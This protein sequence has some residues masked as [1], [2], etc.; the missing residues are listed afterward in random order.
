MGRER[1]LAGGRGHRA[2]PTVSVR[3]ARLVI[4]ALEAR[5]VDVAA[6]LATLRVDRATLDDPDA[7]LS[8][9]VHDALCAE[10]PRLSGDDHIGLH[11]GERLPRSAFDI[12]AYTMRNSP[13]LGGAFERLARYIRLLHDV[14]EIGLHVDRRTARLTFRLTPEGTPRQQA[15]FTLAVFVQFCR[16]ATKTDVV[17]QAVEF[18]HPAPAD[19][20]EHER[21]F[22]APLSFGRPTTALLLAREALDLPLAYA[23]A[24]LLGLLERQIQERV[25]RLPQGESVVDRA[26]RFLAGELSGGLPNLETVAR[27]MRM[28]PRTLHRRLREGETSFRALLDG[29][30][31]DLAA[32]YL[33]EDHMPI[34]EA[35]FLL[36]FS[37]A[38]A[39]HRSF[40]RWTGQTPAEY[41]RSEGARP[42]ASPEGAP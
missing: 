32:R 24:A 18:S 27:R 9:R 12:I 35:A 22:R 21:I 4:L 19:V 7:R 2:A 14:A 33:A 40:K 23:D 41:R 6:F 31:H 29:L 30:R 15:E 3:F 36:G 11:L 10:A 1:G 17:P 5:G 25:A 20:S 38:S 26:R 39:F 37:E 42:A 16:Q 13:T 8:A 34:A 28:S